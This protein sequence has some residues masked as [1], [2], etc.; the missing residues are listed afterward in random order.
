[1][2][3]NKIFDEEIAK[4][5]N[6]SKKF[7]GDEIKVFTK[8]VL[9][10]AI[11]KMRRHTNRHIRNLYQSGH[12]YVGNLVGKTIDFSKVDEM[13]IKAITDRKVLWEAYANIGK[14]LSGKINDVITES[15][16]DPKTFSIGNMVNKMKDVADAETYRLERIV[17]TETRTASQ[18]GREMG[19]KKAD[20]DG[21]YRYN[22][23][24]KHDSRTSPICKEIEE[25]VTKEGNGR[26]VTLD[27]L[28]EILK[29][30]SLKHNGDKWEYRD[31]TPH[32][33]CRSGLIRSFVENPQ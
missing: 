25:F 6:S 11:W 13:A 24:V 12:D 15:Y 23:A 30:V 3:L 9:D 5:M 4:I 18:K 8:K 31:W 10:D 2:E 1:M 28:N 32:I 27:R 19:F 16:A 20:P 26:G 22:W 29:T 17:R 7:S 14:E 21:A 33:N